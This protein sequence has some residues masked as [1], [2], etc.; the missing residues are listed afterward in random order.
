METYFYKDPRI[1]E[2]IDQITET[3]FAACLL[4]GVDSEKEFQKGCQIV[5][6]LSL[7]LQGISTFPAEYLED[8][9][10]QLLEQHLPDAQVINNFPTFHDTLDRMLCEGISKSINSQTE[11]LLSSS[12]PIQDQA[13]EHSIAEQDENSETTEQVVPDELLIEIAIPALASCELKCPEIHEIKAKEDTLNTKA[14]GM[15]RTSQVPVHAVPLQRILSNIFP[16]SSV[17]WNFD[18]KG[19]IF[20]AQVKNILIYLSDL[21]QPILIE[22]FAKEGWKVY[23]CRPEDLSFPRRIERGIK[24]TL[25]SGMK[26]QII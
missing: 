13:K 15:V 24:Q 1:T 9:L 10:K 2:W 22:D 17:C 26:S 16:N 3:V 6:K 23:V 25:R 14:Y 18:I 20:L 12:I 8:G 4:T 7:M 21:E 19:Q 5:S 11:E